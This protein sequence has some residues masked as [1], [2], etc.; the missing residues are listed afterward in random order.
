MSKILITGGAGYIGSHT[1]VDLIENNFTNL[2][3]V[4]NFSNSSKDT[5]D[6]IKE[7]TGKDVKNYNVDLCN[8]E[9]TEKIFEENRDISG[10][11]HFA[12]YKA[13]GE[14]VEK[15]L[16]YYHNNIESLV[17]M[18]KLAKKYNVPNIIFSSSCSVYGNIDKLPVTEDT[19]LPKAES[20]YAYTKQIGERMLQDFLKISPNQKAIALRYFNPVGAHPTGK[21][22][23]M[24]IGVPNNLVPFIT[25]TAI[26]I[27]EKLT[28][29]GNDY[30]TKDGTCIRDYIHVSDIAHAHVLALQKL[31][32]DKN[33][34]QYD[35]I[36]LGTGNGVS[37]KKV[38]DAFEKVTGKKL[39]YEYGPRRPGD[40]VAI[41]ANNQKAIKVLNWTPKY[42]LN[43]MMLSAWKWEK[44]LQQA[45][46]N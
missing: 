6:R 21:L 22:G 2:I 4:D 1:I 12:A 8:L 11:I 35:V 37:V 10:I 19:P 9:Q 46:V 34:P 27:R 26:G 3:S 14:S 20:P 25:Q 36:N 31:M 17:N 29:F 24:P 39:N 13:V 44:N 7:I 42:N 32:N 15:P 33:F 16:K 30:P 28:I 38:V 5:F 23:E 45:N 43:D 41:Y 18:L 40:A